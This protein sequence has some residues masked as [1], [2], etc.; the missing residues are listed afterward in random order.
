MFNNKTLI[1]MYR[2][3]HRKE[4]S[5]AHRSDSGLESIGTLIGSLVNVMGVLN[6]LLPRHYGGLIRPKLH[7]KQLPVALLHER[8]QTPE[9]RRPITAAVC[10]GESRR[11]RRSVVLQHR[12]VV[13]RHRSG[14]R[15]R[16][17]RAP[18]QELGYENHGGKSNWIL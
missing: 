5:E 15:L 12:S 6:Q 14:Y 16:V 9:R 8:R 10:G 13:L 1:T 7:T 17:S 18:F 11:R 3:I 4:K 2:E